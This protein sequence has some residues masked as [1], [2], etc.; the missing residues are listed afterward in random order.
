M[1]WGDRWRLSTKWAEGDGFGGPSHTLCGGQ[2]GRGSSQNLRRK[3][4][5]LCLAASAHSSPYP[6][7]HSDRAGASAPSLPP[8]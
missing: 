8:H 4:E 3:T 2:K 5:G 6:P 1:D 7:P